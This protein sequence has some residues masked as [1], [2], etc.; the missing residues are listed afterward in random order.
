MIASW[1]LKISRS[2]PLIHVEDP[3]D[4]QTPAH[5]VEEVGQVLDVMHGVARDDEMVS[6]WLELET[7]AIGDV[8]DER[9]AVRLVSC[10]RLAADIETVDTIEGQRDMFEEATART[11]C[12]RRA[13]PRR[14]SSPDRKPASARTSLHRHAR[15]RTVE[16]P[17]QMDVTTWSTSSHTTRPHLD[18]VGL[19]PLPLGGG[20][21]RL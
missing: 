13:A 5:L 15:T 2:D 8:P 16:N 6:A 12:P 10:Q 3:A 9:D 19:V 20:E 1:D 11:A 17:P 4:L 14:C 21:R 7:I 18:D